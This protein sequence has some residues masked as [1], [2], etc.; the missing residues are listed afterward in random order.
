[1][2]SATRS[3]NSLSDNSLDNRIIKLLKGTFG[4]SATTLVRMLI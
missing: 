3:E 4:S 1:V 2:H